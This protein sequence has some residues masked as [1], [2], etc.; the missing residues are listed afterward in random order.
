MEESNLQKNTGGSEPKKPLIPWVAG[1]EVFSRISSWIVVPVVLALV[2][3][4][5]LDRKFGTAP[6]IFLVLTGLG[7]LVT[8]YGIVKIARDYNKDTTKK[9]SK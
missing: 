4:K 3:G 2:G 7:F 9:N 5:M 8:C 1:I 6:I